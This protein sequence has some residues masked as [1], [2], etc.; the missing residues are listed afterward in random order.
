MSSDELKKLF[1][2]LLV[3][4]EDLAR[5]LDETVKINKI[6]WNKLKNYYSRENHREKR[7]Q[8]EHST[9]ETKTHITLV[10]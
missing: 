1:S 3:K 4:I 7:Q 5:D 10:F 2:E 6:I 9:R 8:L